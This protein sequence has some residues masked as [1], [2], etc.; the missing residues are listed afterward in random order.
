M[1]FLLSILQYGFIGIG[2][3]AILLFAQPVFSQEAPSAALPED[4][5]L[6]GKVVKVLD[7]TDQDFVHISEIVQQV[8]VR[9]I[10]GEK[11]GIEVAAQN[12]IT[13]GEGSSIELKEGDAI[14][15][16]EAYGLD[17]RSYFVSDLYRLPWLWLV[18]GIFIVLVFLFSH[19]RGLM[20]LVGLG[21]SIV[22]LSGYIV[23]TI[24]RG[25]DPMTTSIIGSIGI[26]VSS[27]YLAHGFKKR[28]SLALASTFIVLMC[29]AVLAV[30]F[31]SLA[32]LFGNGTE[33]ALFVQLG[34]GAAVNLKGLLLGGII[35]GTLGILDDVT[36]A[37]TAAVEE[38][39][40]ANPA[41]SFGE[42]YARGLSVGREHI[43]SLVNTLV[44]AYAGASLPLFLLFFV[45]KGQPWWVIVNGEFVAE[46][47]VRTL[48]GSS[49]LVL[50]VPIT[51]VL[52]A[53]IYS[54]KK[55]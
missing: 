43:S 33:E 51:T 32:Q 19:F 17:G 1:N 35:I 42:L 41:L 10:K 4:T 36:T 52:A 15:L 6:I 23:P 21:V 16:V 24:L 50:A 38:I 44:L 28:T 48:V 3:C 54:K 5:Y 31:V 37:Q 53:Y 47:I 12:I 34:S 9:I 7:S 46:E 29:T 27:L 22:V 13:S 30:L 20:S 18:G 55:P 49:A 14:M 40:R 2:A 8:R 26:L 39:H 45:N 11:K 25:G